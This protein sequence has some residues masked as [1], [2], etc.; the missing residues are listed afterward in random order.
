[1]TVNRVGSELQGTW[2]LHNLFFLTRWLRHSVEEVTS[3]HPKALFFTL[4]LIKDYIL[5]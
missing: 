4:K 3:S 5:K 2:K 1:M